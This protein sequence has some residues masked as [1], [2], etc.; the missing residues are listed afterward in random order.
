MQKGRQKPWEPL[1]SASQ[2][3]DGTAAQFNASFVPAARSQVGMQ[4]ARFAPVAVALSAATQTALLKAS[5]ASTFPVQS[6]TQRPSVGLPPSQSCDP[7]SK[8]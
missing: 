5:H 8:Q 3:E 4:S 7:G 2:A 6:A 1:C